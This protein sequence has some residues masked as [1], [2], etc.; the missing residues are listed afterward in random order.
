MSDPYASISPNERITM[1]KTFKSLD[2]LK[3]Y[4]LAEKIAN[5]EKQKKAEQALLNSLKGNK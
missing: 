3:D 2:E 4:V 5:Y 1:T